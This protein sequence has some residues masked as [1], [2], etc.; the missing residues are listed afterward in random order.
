MKT[1]EGIRRAREAFVP[2]NDVER[3]LIIDLLY[4]LGHCD[5]MSDA[6]DLARDDLK[7]SSAALEHAAVELQRRGKIEDVARSIKIRMNG[8]VIHISREDILKL[9]QVLA[10]NP[11]PDHG[12]GP[13]AKD[14]TGVT[15]TWVEDIRKGESLDQWAKRRRGYAD[16]MADD[17]KP[18]ELRD[19]SATAKAEMDTS[20][21]ALFAGEDDFGVK[22]RRPTRPE[23]YPESVLAGEQII[24]VGIGHETDCPIRHIETPPLCPWCEKPIEFEDNAAAVGDLTV[25]RD[26]ERDQRCNN[27][28]GTG[29]IIVR[30][31]ADG[32][33]DYLNGMPS[34]EIDTCSICQGEG[35]RI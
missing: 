22:L 20:P 1:I 32:Q 31:N 4:L 12:V 27:C 21:F 23:E 30:R 8:G 3:A 13:A 5:Q 26:C 6:L 34:G 24:S 33:V 9:N 25:H 18:K 19:P 16:A 28:G 11:K 35:Y 15:L 29:E 2:R 17:L 7:T 10:D 14:M